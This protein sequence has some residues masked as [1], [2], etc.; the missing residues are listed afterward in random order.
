MARATGIHLILATQRPS[1]DIITGLIKANITSRI[2]FA[3]ASM[4]DSRTIL[5]FSG[6][7]KLLG[8]GDMLFISPSLSKPKRLQAPYVSDEEIK[9][10]VEFLRNIS[11]PDYLEEITNFQVKEEKEGGEEFLEEDELLDQA[12]EIVIKTGKASATLLQRYLRIG[13]A[14]AARLLDLLE[15]EGTIGPPDGARPRRVLKKEEDLNQK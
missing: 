10:I 7:E 9:K 14:R 1:V 15:K 12:R 3:V 6:A 13:Y 5:D 2:A 4:S 11:E 8:R